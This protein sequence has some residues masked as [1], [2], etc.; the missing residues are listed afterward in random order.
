MIQNETI[1]KLGRKYRTLSAALSERSRRLWAAAEAKELGWGGV[2]A[3]AKATGLSR[4]TIARG[5]RELQAP[6]PLEPS[7]VRRPGGGRKRAAVLDPTLVDDLQRL[8]EPV[9]RGDPESPLR[10]T[11]KSTRR[12]AKELGGMGHKASHTLVAA[13][14]H[15]L[16]Y[17]LQANRKTREGTSHPDRNAQFEHINRTAAAFLQRQQPTISVDTKKKELVG[18]F[19]NGGRQWRPQGDPQKV[20]VHDFPDKKLGKAVPYGVYDVARNTGWVSVGMDHDT[21]QFAV[22]TIRRWWRRMGRRRY[23]RAAELLIVA[24]S[25]GS[26]GARVRLWKWEL[27]K[28]ANETG[29]VIRV[30]HLPPGTSKWNKIEHRLFSFITKNWR[31]RPL[32]THATIVNLIASTTTEAGLVVRCALDTR[33]YAPKIRVSDKQMATIHLEPDRFHGD[34]NYAIRPKK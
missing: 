16:G 25:G 32:L 7:R 8:V 4:L 6:P 15:E 10:W 20:R 34:W 21:A 5:V 14:L 2:S 22:N 29:M 30:C 1:E 13:L 11:C 12:L 9:T 17:S 28:L 33:K 24:D 27:Q 18:D 23:P 31:G 3:V 26:N 19:K